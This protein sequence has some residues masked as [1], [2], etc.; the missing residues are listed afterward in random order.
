MGAK[1]TFVKIRD[2]VDGIGKLIAAKV[3]YAEVEFFDSPSGPRLVKVRVRSHLVRR[4][5]LSRQTRVFMFEPDSG[6]WRAGR[7]DEL[8]ADEQSGNEEHYS[9]KFPNGINERVPVS[10]LFVRWARPIADPTEYLAAKITDT[11]FFF[12]GRSRIVRHLAKQRA[13]FGGLTGL[14]SSAVELL[15]HQISIVRRVLR[16]PIQRYLLADEV[17]LGKTIEAGVLIRQHILDQPIDADVLVIVPDHL[18]GQWKKELATKF[19]I[20]AEDCRLTLVGSTSLMGEDADDSQHSLVVID[21]AHK[22]ASLAFSTSASEL[23]AFDRICRIALTSSRLLLLSGTPVLRQENQFLAMLHLIDP[24][25]YPL[26]NLDAFRKRVQERQTVAEATVDL[27][28]NASGMFADEAVSKILDAF[29]NDDR[30]TQLCSRVKELLWVP[31]DSAERISALRELRTHLTET[32]KLHRRL[33]RTRRSDPRVADLL[34]SRNGA[35]SISHEDQARTEASQF[36]DTWRLS[37]ENLDDQPE[38]LK[39]LFAT[40]VVAAMAHP[41]VLVR[42]IKKRLF[43]LK[44][45][46]PRKSDI[47]QFL[48]FDGERELLTERMELIGSLV[49]EDNRCTA[50]ADW[51]NSHPEVRKIVVFVSDPEIADYVCSD[52]QHKSRHV[53]VIRYQGRTVQLRDFEVDRS[54][55]FL[56]CDQ[57]AEEGLNLQRGGTAIV[58]YDLPLDPMRIEQRIG[59]VDRIEANARITNV[60]VSQHH[61]YEYQWLE[62]LSE[63]IGVFNR[64]IA[65]LQYLLSESVSRI[66]GRLLTAG[67]D[68]FGDAGTGGPRRTRSPMIVVDASAVL[69]ALLR[70]P[71]AAAV[72]KRLFEPFERM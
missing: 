19:F 43:Q 15:E 1:E 72:E 53:P 9:V 49:E 27:T 8:I 13:A 52:L 23:K 4:V 20:S 26:S 22:I 7:I 41:R 54:R 63:G 14:A 66:H 70:T 25:G 33:L 21:E 29:G 39:Q 35:V 32:Y 44:G 2:N 38:Y 65:P 34:P 31:E 69:E 64:S 11:P 30:L 18:I 5:T 45:G 50:I 40:F 16:D 46:S 51:A 6:I 48:A 24:D 56:V 10:R 71:A 60:V 62:C 59:R 58:H 55:R 67:R 37:L 42:E 68:A 12:E 47:D 36:L 28:D 17:G 61:S 3:D 57:R